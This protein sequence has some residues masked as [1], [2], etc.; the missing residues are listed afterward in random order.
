MNRN[1]FSL[2]FGMMADAKAMPDVKAFAQALEV[3]FDDLRALPLP[4]ELQAEDAQARVG[5]A[6]RSVRGAVTQS[7]SKTVQGAMTR[8]VGQVMR[9]A[10]QAAAKGAARKPAAAKPRA[11]RA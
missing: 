6:L 2:D 8:A 7:V 11:R 4:H 5:R 1:S 9:G 3:A 10:V